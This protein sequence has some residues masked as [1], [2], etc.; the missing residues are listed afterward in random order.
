MKRTQ[1]FILTGIIVFLLAG[2]INGEI[3]PK[4]SPDVSPTPSVTQSPTP[5][6]IV[7]PEELSI[8][9][10]ELSMD[11][12]LKINIDEEGL[13]TREYSNV[14]GDS[15]TTSRNLSPEEIVR[16]I[17][18]I[19]SNKFFELPERINDDSGITCMTFRYLT[20]T[21]DGKSHRRGGDGDN[22]NFIAICEY[23]ERLAG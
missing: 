9:F 11:E 4:N 15:D 7:L 5:E 19:Q 17:E 13:L 18:V 1:I 16:L 12:T 20:I 14:F 8:F 10:E 6:D 21:F 22:R 3:I 2:C 23:I